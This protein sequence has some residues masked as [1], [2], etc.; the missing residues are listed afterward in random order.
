[1]ASPYRKG[2]LTPYPGGFA[3]KNIETNGVT[4]HT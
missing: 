2:E 3:T 4:I 1:M